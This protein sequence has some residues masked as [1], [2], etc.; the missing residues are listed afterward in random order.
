VNDQ[1]TT[2]VVVDDD[3]LTGQRHVTVLAL[4]W[5][6]DDPLAVVVA[7]SSQPE[8]PSLPRGL[9]VVLRDFLRYGASE[10]TG[11]GDVRIRPAVGGRRVLLELRPNCKDTPYAVHVP[12]D[13]LCHFLDR[14]EALVPAGSEAGDAAMD[15]LIRRL[16]DA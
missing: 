5:T 9:W 7:L 13:V 14:T 8:H 15:E 3:G 2:S 12:T 4:T 6:P 1:V 11:D 16:L 10:P